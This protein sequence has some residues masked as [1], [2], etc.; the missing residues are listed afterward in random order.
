MRAMETESYIGKYVCYG[1][2]N[3]MFCWGK[4]ES[5]RVINTAKGLREVFVLVD[6]MTGPHNGQI[7]HIQGRTTVRKELLNLEKDIFTKKMGMEDLTDDQLFLFVLSGD[8]ESVHLGLMNMLRSE[9]S[10]EKL[11]KVAKDELE[12]RMGNK[13][14]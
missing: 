2:T 10:K 1:N 4:I 7:I 3:G 9:S 11:E 12:S 14:E 5:E 6:R 13:Q 8:M